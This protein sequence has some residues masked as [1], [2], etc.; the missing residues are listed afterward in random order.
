M[1]LNLSQVA[2]YT[3]LLQRVTDVSHAQQRWLDWGGARSKVVKKP[4]QRRFGS[5]CYI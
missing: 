4:E 1:L 2:I 3:Q 5:V